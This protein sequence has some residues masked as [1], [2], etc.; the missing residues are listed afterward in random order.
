MYEKAKKFHIQGKKV[1]LADDLREKLDRLEEMLPAVK[2]MDSGQVL[3]LLHKLD[4]VETTLNNIDPNDLPGERSR[5][6]SIQ[7][8]F[9]KQ[10][11]RLLRNLGGAEVL[12]Q[13]RV[14]GI[15]ESERWWWHLDRIVA[16]NRRQTLKRAGM[17]AGVIAVIIGALVVL[18]NTILKPSPEAVARL[19]AENR[20]YGAIELGDYEE[21]LLAIDEGLVKVPGDV[22][23]LV[24]RGA[25]LQSLNRNDEAEVVFEKVQEELGPIDYHLALAQVYLRVGQFEQSE[26]EAKTALEIERESARGWMALGQAQELQGKYLEALD[27]F[28]VAS[29]LAYENNEN[30]LYVMARISLARLTEAMPAMSL[31]QPT[32]E[33]QPGEGTLESAE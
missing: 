2:R 29:Q 4:E 30:E 27:S 15:V 14:S 23:L 1:S 20:A 9:R 32:I 7:G 26:E 21:A 16:K 5:F 24:V 22:S 25:L 19:E 10:S 11:G 17:V 31:E 8:R 13:H 6:E 18:F 3:A 33:P 28:E 12:R